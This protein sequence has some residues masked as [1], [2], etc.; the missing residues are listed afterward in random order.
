MQVTQI[1]E[2]SKSRS[3][4][5]IDG[6]FAFV[7]YK[8]ELRL[9]HV[10]SGE[11]LAEKDYDTIVK[12]VL[13]KR[14]K[15]RAMNLLQKREYTTSQLRKKLEQGLYPGEVIE[16]ALDYVSSYHYTD[17]L[18][19][20]LQY[21]IFHVDSR[22]HKRIDRDLLGKGV[23]GEVISAAWQEWEEQGGR[24]DETEMIRKLLEKRKFEPETADYAECQKQ[25]A[26]LARKGFSTDK[27]YK[28]LR[29]FT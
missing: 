14:A 27:I 23:S 7:L 18:R 19:Y 21:I 17:D 29:T 16:D 4:V 5:Y 12:E 26:F 13:P 9:Y 24:Q 25:A 11:T 20:A 8:G 22:S 1:E 3:K 6:E 10:K 15:L 28:V 2:F